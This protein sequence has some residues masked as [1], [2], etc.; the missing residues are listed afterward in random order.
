LAQAFA[1]A[2]SRL[3]G[4]RCHNEPSLVG[5][6]LSSGPAGRPRR[7]WQ[8]HEEICWII[9]GRRARR[10]WKQWIPAVLPEVHGEVQLRCRGQ[11]RGVHVQVCGRLCRQVHA[12]FRVIPSERQ[13]AGE[14]GGEG[15]PAAPSRPGS[16]PSRH[17]GRPVQGLRLH[18]QVQ[19]LLQ[20]V[21][22]LPQVWLKQ[23]W[24]CAPGCCGNKRDP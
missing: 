10:F 17:Q 8:I 4:C 14:P 23:L 24:R 11:L 13:H 16:R 6:A 22:G 3:L 20:G 12:V 1:Q 21:F 7:L 15:V 18:G 5:L 19:P 9:C 2:L